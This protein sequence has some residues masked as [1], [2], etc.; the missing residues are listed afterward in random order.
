MSFFHTAI[1]SIESVISPIAVK[2]SSQ[3]HINAVKDGF[4]ATMPFLIVG[5]LILVFAFP[6]YEEGFF[7]S[8]WK[9]LIELIGHNNIMAP[10]H[11]SMG[12]FALYAAYSIGY[13]LAESY[14]LS[15]KNTGLLSM[16]G[17]LLA[18]SPLQSVET[19]G[20]VLPAANLGAK[21]AFTAI[22]CGLL[23]PELQRALIRFNIRIRLPEAV[24][25]KISASFD[26]LI[27][28]VFVAII[29][30]AINTALGYADLNIPT[31]IMNMFKP[32]VV[33]SDSFAACIL[34]ILLIQMLWFCG[35]H[36]GSVVTQGILFPVLLL[37]LGLNQDAMEAGLELPKIFVSPLLDFFVF[38]GGAGGTFGFVLLMVRSKSAH[39]KAIGRMS[40][41]P[42]AFNINEPVIFGAPIV[43]NPIYFIPWILAPITNASIVW[44]CFKYDLISKIVALPPWTMP[45]PIGA[46]IATNSGKAALVVLLCILI[47]IAIYYPFFKSH[48]KQLLLEEQPSTT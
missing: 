1:S 23:I 46:V 28:I 5:S 13:S 9:A 10:F 36:G 42:G 29:V 44:F 7:F 22:L 38:I 17:F 30:T 39:L 27:P 45:A 33:A 18:A 15:A 35:I 12:I 43:M 34:A 2:V 19:V 48:E 25:P 4:V 24:P 32:L 47:S 16:F 37:N 8:G 40:I 14:R 31:A 11:V 41:V 6:P 21:G 20:G 3:K 26:L